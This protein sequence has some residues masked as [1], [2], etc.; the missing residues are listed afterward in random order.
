MRTGGTTYTAAVITM[1]SVAIVLGRRSTALVTPQGRVLSHRFGQR[2]ISSTS[3]RQN[4]KG[5][6]GGDGQK[7]QGGRVKREKNVY[8][9]T[10]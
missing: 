4:A 5:K 7:K 9:S 10:I 6:Q 2:A 1:I 3:L 8:A